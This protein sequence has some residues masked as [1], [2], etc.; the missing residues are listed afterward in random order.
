MKPANLDWTPWFLVKYK[1]NLIGHEKSQ[2]IHSMAAGP[3]Q[4][5]FFLSLPKN[6]TNLFLQYPQIS[7]I[8]CGEV[9]ALSADIYSQHER[10]SGM[11][12]REHK[13]KKVG[14]GRGI[15]GAGKRP[16]RILCSIPLIWVFSY[17]PSSCS[18]RTPRLIDGFLGAVKKMW[19]SLSRCDQ[20]LLK[21]SSY[22]R[23]LK[24]SS[25]SHRNDV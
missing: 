20:V 22:K 18:A 15:R 17:Y 12:I 6:K 2:L 19:W 8:E 14:K 3:Y 10:Y 24:K 21:R 4:L 1:F 7:L 16:K 23:I 25:T 11:A 13:H 5:N 9:W